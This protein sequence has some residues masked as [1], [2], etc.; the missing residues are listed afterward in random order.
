MGTQQIM[1][2][3]SRKLGEIVGRTTLCSVAKKMQHYFFKLS[4][5]E[6]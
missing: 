3:Y 2:K 6:V 5:L 1:F 4:V